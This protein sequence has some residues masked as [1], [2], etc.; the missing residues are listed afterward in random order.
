M[1]KETVTGV[2]VTPKGVT[3]CFSELLGNSIVVYLEPGTLENQSDID[4]GELHEAA[5]RWFVDKLG[6]STSSFILDDVS[7]DYGEPTVKITFVNDGITM[8]KL[9]GYIT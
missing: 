2:T 3:G 8:A 5:C 9:Q 6:F 4:Y 1:G 7:R